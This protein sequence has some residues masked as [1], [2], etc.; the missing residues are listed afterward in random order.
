[1]KSSDDAI[2]DEK[3]YCN[4]CN[5]KV[6]II[7]SKPYPGYKE[8]LLNCGH[9]SKLFE[10]QLNGIATTESEAIGLILSKFDS[11]ENITIEKKSHDLNVYLTISGQS[12]TI[13]LCNKT[14]KI[15]ILEANN[16]VKEFSSNLSQNYILHKIDI[17]IQ[18]VKVNTEDTNQ[19]QEI[20]YFLDTLKNLISFTP[21]AQNRFGRFKNWISPKR[22]VFTAESRYILDIIKE[23][24]VSSYRA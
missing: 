14:I 16:T 23:V 19:T 24:I 2:M 5:K 4:V 7:N 21:S 22:W 13:I 18:N 3:H 15:N 9:R 1:M 12:I 10:A 17:L 20:M 11:S 6:R 8:R